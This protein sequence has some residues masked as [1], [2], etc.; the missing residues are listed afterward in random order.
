MRRTRSLPTGWYP[1]REAEVRDRLRSWEEAL[2]ETDGDFVAAVVPH[3]GWVFSGRI[4]FRTI[5]MLR[6]PVDTIVVAGGHLRADDPLLVAPEDGFET[7]LG[8]IARDDDLARCLTDAFET[9]PDNVADNTVEVHLP[10][11]RY[12][13]PGSAVVCVRCPPGP[14][15]SRVG[16]AIAG[17]AVA[18]ER[19]IR[20]VGSTD[21]THYG[22]AYGFTPAGHGPAAVAWVRDENDRAIVDSMARMDAEETVR[23]AHERR[24][25]CSSGAAAAAISFARRLG[26]RTGHVI[27]YA[28]SYDVRP[29]A[30]FGGYAGVGY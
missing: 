9:A 5:R 15:A 2:P 12:L 16:E 29:D 21:L 6:A 18:H 17:Y 14:L 11:V 1:A 20:V 10:I 4:A 3:A 7:P 25:A 8:D 23:L 22:P 26:A 30:S 13:F 28:Q 27:E 19:S 24:A